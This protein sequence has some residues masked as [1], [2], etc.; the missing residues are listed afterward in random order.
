MVFTVDIKRDVYRVIQRE[1]RAAEGGDLTRGKKGIPTTTGLVFIYY[2]DSVCG[3]LFTITTLHSTLSNPRIAQVGPVRSVH[4][5]ISHKK[6]THPRSKWLQSRRD[7]FSTYQRCPVHLVASVGSGTEHV[8]VSHVHCWHRD[9]V[10]F[11]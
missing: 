1:T 4:A 10:V 8:L 7:P 9:I 2:F 3:T 11:G 5:Y 6:M